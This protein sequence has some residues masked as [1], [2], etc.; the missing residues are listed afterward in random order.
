MSQIFLK[1]GLSVGLL[2]AMQAC[3]STTKTAM[4][5]ANEEDRIAALQVLNQT[6]KPTAN[7]TTTTSTDI[8]WI[9]GVLPWDRFT[10][11][12]ISPN[13]LHAAVQLG[14]P[15]KIS[16]LCGNDDSVIDST[17][18][19]LHI[20]DP[21]EGRRISPLH[22]GREG[23][24]L[25][26]AADDHGVLVEVPMGD[27][28]RSIGKIEWA[29]GSLN[30]L[31]DDE[32]VNAFPTINSNHDLAWSRRVANEN[33]FYL[34]LQTL[35]GQRIID[36]AV[37]D[38]ILPRFLGNDRL[39]VF[40]INNGTLSLVELD[41]RAR[42]PLLTS[43]T[44]PIVDEGATRKLAWQ[45]SSTTQ[46]HYWHR[47]HAFYHPI[48][49]RMVLWEPN[50]SEELIALVPGSISATPA[51]DDTWLVATDHRIL[52]QRVGDDEGIYLR[53]KLAIPMATTSDQW[54]H[55]LLIPQG[56]RLQVHAINLDD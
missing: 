4:P 56:N 23:L 49:H 22:I 2:G 24:I 53:N 37:S 13:G 33:R 21:I 29:T 9:A 52:R 51:S 15:P 8:D 5:Q 31:V 45:I 16:S 7:S 17:T 19:E 11:P 54:T 39:R 34:V 32:Y 30:W 6:I 48:L 50:L 41:L 47:T 1:Y 18:I 38:W 12:V 35:R 36:D 14:T 10:L 28:T 26:P 27:G 20:L 40:K 42:D 25:S 55:F 46:T 3:G 43:I 44:L